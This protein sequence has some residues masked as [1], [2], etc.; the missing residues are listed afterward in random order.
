M[1]NVSKNSTKKQIAKKKSKNLCKNMLI[2]CHHTHA[3]L[4]QYE[5]ALLVKARLWV[6]LEWKGWPSVGQKIFCTKKTSGHMTCW[7][8]TCWQ[9]MWH[10]EKLIESMRK[11]HLISHEIIL[12]S[13]LS[14]NPL[15]SIVKFSCKTTQTEVAIIHTHLFDKRGMHCWPKPPHVHILSEAFSTGCFSSV[16]YIDNCLYD[17]LHVR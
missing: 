1:L 14:R 17:G 5:N 13:H 8:I 3:P 9:F 11:V 2:F 12:H 6:W 15:D 4:W 10:E 7:Q 16:V